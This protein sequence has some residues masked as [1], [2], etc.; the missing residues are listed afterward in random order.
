MYVWNQQ[1]LTKKR[2]ARTQVPPI[3]NKASSKEKRDG[4]RWREIEREREP[5]KTKS[6]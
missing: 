6:N 4:E 1:A 2:S 5:V 3:L